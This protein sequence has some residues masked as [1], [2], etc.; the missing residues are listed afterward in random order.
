MY[1]HT[2][3]QGC[4][5]LFNV[6]SE[7]TAESDF[8][9]SLGFYYFYPFF[10]FIFYVFIFIFLFLKRGVNITYINFIIG[11]KEGGRINVKSFRLL[12]FNCFFS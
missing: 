2:K 11:R 5:G 4:Y 10:F 3:E 1:V 8:N 9:I 7:R 12:G 6:F